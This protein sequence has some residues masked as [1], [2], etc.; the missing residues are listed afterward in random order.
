MSIEIHGLT[1]RFGSHLIFDHFS[2]NIPVGETTLITGS[3]G[4]GKTT[5]LRIIARLD[6]HYRGKVL[7]VP[8]RISYMFQE[9][10]LLPWFTLKQNIEFVLKDEMNGPEL[11]EKVQAMIDAVQLNGHE[12][13]KPD[14]LSGGMK[15]R[16]AMA[17]AYVY[18]ADLLI[19]DEPFKGLDADL[20]QDMIALFKKQIEKKGVTAILV[21]HDE[22]V[23]SNIKCNV[24]SL[25]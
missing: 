14:A 7:G 5:L 20:K 13:K 12:D 3:S 2:V 19:M 1:K 11:D 9:D 4:E 17:R 15:R 24:I 18:D 22:A 21:S 6:H 16:V 10:R 23:I 8:E 25:D